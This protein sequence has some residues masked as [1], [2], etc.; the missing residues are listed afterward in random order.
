MFPIWNKQKHFKRLKIADNSIWTS[1]KIKTSEV[2]IHMI[3]RK[4]KDQKMTMIMSLWTSAKEIIKIRVKIYRLLILIG[5]KKVM[6]IIRIQLTKITLLIKKEITIKKSKSRDKK[7]HLTTLK[8]SLILII[9]RF[10]MQQLFKKITGP[11]TKTQ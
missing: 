8:K 6:K 5:T 1:Y 9:R 4:K 7:T 2:S 10:R 11:R 3:E